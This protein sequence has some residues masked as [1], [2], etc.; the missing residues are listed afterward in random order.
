LTVW[1][2]ANDPQSA[3]ARADETLAASQRANTACLGHAKELQGLAQL[4]TGRPEAVAQYLF[5]A[6]Q[7]F[8]DIGQRFCT[9]HCTESIAWWCAASN[10]A[11]TSGELLAAAE[12]VRL[13]SGRAR[14]GFEQQAIR[15]ATNLLDGLPQA[16]NE[17]T[18]DS[19]VN[20]ARTAIRSQH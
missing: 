1:T 2:I 5:E 16:D 14:A 17:T 13:V 11:T 4:A 15:G 19:V 8:E 18:L 7:P 20:R 3:P 10:D 6:T 9:L 12:G